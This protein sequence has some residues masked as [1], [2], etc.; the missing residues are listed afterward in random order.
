MMP[1]G[2]ISA[3]AAS[4]A[5]LLFPSPTLTHT[6]ASHAALLPE[7]QCNNMPQAIMQAGSYTSHISHEAALDK[8]AR[9]DTLIC[10]N[11]QLPWFMRHARGTQQPACAH[12]LQVHMHT[13][14]TQR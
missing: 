1:S 4:V 2:T 11:M 3:W 10:T 6:R 7:L 5:R 8:A 12:A 9:G 13:T 14:L